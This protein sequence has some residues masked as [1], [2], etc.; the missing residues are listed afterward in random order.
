[1]LINRKY[2]LFTFKAC[3]NVVLF[4][5]ISAVCLIKCDEINLN[6]ASIEVKQCP[7]VYACGWRSVFNPL[8]PGGTIALHPPPPSKT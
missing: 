7:K 4:S 3:P 5:V 2:F 8:M 6:F 1:M